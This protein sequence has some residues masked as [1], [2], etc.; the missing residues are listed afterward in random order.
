MMVINALILKDFYEYR[1]NP[2]KVG[3]T[4]LL[5]TII[6]ILLFNFFGLSE[7]YLKD[8]RKFE[9]LIV[10]IY[11]ALIYTETTLFQT[12]REINC[13]IFEKFFIH[14]QIK[15]I[16]ILI[17]KYLTNLIISILAL[18]FILFS[19]AIISIFIEEAIYF[20]IRVSFIFQ[21][22][23]GCGIGT[24]LAFVCSIVI[25]DEKN[26]A[27]YL[28]VLVSFYFGYYKLLE[29]L[30]I[31]NGIIEYIGLGCITYLLCFCVLVLF[32]QNQFIRK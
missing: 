23:L 1:N 30:K 8:M 7:F 4:F 27:I 29:F 9:E 17:S 13:G 12:R 10:I 24:C 22:I 26:I 21:L 14:S 15:R 5:M 19:N 16:D 6:P 3:S 25:H 20:S 18:I 11:I 2:V 32:R 28:F 31:P